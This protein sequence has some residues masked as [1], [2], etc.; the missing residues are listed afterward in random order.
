MPLPRNLS[1]YADV[2]K[3]LRAALAAG[4]ARVRAPSPNM[5][6]RWRQRAYTFRKRLLEYDEKSPSVQVGARVASTPYDSMTIHLVEGSD[7]L[8]LRFGA[9]MQV[10]VIGPDS[11]PLS[12]DNVEEPQEE[13]P[14]EETLAQAKRAI[15][16]L[17][18]D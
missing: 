2:E 5:A 3:V 1:A 12:L 9:A 8:E 18:T 10:E 16:D 15:L 13:M 17:K 6:L 4:G 7:E 11:K 14:D